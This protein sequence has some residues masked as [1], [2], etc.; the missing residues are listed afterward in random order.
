MTEADPLLAIDDLTVEFST[1]AGQ[2][3]AVRG[4]S[5]HVDA[6]ETVALLGES[7]SGK[8]VTVQ[9]IMGLL[10]KTTSRVASGQVSYRG[11]DLLALPTRRLR[12]FC[13]PEIAMVFQDPLSSLNP[14]MRVGYQLSEPLWRGAGASRKAARARAIELMQLVGI[15]D[16]ARRIDDYPHQ[17][18]GGMRQRVMIAMALSRNPSLLIADEPT[19]ALDVTV[20]AQI[21]SLLGDLRRELGM[22]MLLISHDLG[23]VADVADRVYVMYAGAIVEEGTTREVYDHPGHPYTEG[24]LASIPGESSGAQRLAS[25]PGSPPVPGTLGDG[26][27]FAPRCRYAT[28]FTRAHEPELRSPAGW[29]PTHRVACHRAEEVLADVRA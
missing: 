24:L 1:H 10:P 5:L 25:I 26:C 11:T 29:V 13:G 14:V 22:A 17:F 6:G 21:M 2:V 15:P 4:V 12:E 18:S 28:E 7:G 3:A 20:Q 9:T 16:A 8:S 23:V 19:T 27:S